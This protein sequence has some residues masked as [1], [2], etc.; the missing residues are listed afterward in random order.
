MNNY[1]NDNGTGLE[2]QVSP[3]KRS[4]DIRQ[5]EKNVNEKNKSACRVDG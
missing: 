3:I 4:L 2:Q 5:S 1:A